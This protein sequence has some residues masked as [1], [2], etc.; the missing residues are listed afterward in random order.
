MSL[1]EYSFC[2]N[3]LHF[4]AHLAPANLPIYPDAAYMRA[5]LGNVHPLRPN[6]YRQPGDMRA[7]CRVS[8]SGKLRC[9]HHYITTSPT[10][11]A[12]DDDGLPSNAVTGIFG[13]VE[14]ANPRVTNYPVLGILIACLTDVS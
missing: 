14:R 2:I 10:L 7:A 6:H 5:V 8:K 11:W 12:Q 1:P 4:H 3:G 13:L 9:A